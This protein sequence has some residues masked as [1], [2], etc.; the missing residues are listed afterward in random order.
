MNESHGTAVECCGID[1]M[2]K[3][4]PT[5][6]RRINT[7]NIMNWIRMI[8]AVFNNP[9]DRLR[10]NSMATCPPLYVTSGVPKNA[11]HSIQNRDISSDQTNALFRTYRKK[12]P[13][14]TVKKTPMVEIIT[15]YLQNVR[16]YWLQ[17]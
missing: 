1:R 13:K 15:P 6:T 3:I 12:T 10:I 17:I 5:Q 14:M 4:V 8:N 11:I 16:M 9:L 7:K 2:D